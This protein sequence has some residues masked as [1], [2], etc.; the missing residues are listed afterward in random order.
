MIIN[1]RVP[2]KEEGEPEEPWKPF[3]EDIAIFTLDAAA[4]HSGQVI[5]T[6]VIGRQS[7]REWVA[8]RLVEGSATRKKNNSPPVD[9]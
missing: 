5:F 7:D 1:S 2:P 8:K 3:K 4:K 9:N 6:S